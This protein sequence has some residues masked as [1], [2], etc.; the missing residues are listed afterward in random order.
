MPKHAASTCIFITYR[1]PS[2]AF[3]DH[4]VFY[5]PYGP[6]PNLRSWLAHARFRAITLSQ[7]ILAVYA[8]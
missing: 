4:Q 1:L 7:L 5:I 8:L 2:N 3:V 6:F